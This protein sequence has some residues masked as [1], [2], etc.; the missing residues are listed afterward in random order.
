M[1]LKTILTPLFVLHHT[2][3]CKISIA[4]SYC[5]YCSEPKKNVT[6]VRVYLQFTELRQALEGSWHDGAD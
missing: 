5:V 4:F 6:H 2:I 1:F 3:E